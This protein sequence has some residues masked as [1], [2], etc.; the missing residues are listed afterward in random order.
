[1]VLI[2]GL[3]SVRI[4]VVISVVL[5]VLV[6]LIVNVLIGIFVGIWMIDSRLFLFDRV[7]FFMGML[8]IGSGVSVV[9]MLG[10]WVV[11]FVLVMMILKFVFL[12]DFVNLYM[13][14]GVWWVEIM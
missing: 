12:V 8:N 6:L 2:V 7:W 14:F 11:L 4:V 10:R 3:F 1:M 9:V 5:V 13:C